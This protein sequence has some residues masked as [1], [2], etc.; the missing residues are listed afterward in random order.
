MPDLRGRHR[1]FRRRAHFRRR[2]QEALLAAPHPQ[3]SPHFGKP[4]KFRTQRH[5]AAL[6]WADMLMSPHEGSMCEHVL[7]GDRLWALASVKGEFFFSRIGFFFKMPIEGGLLKYFG[8][9][10]WGGNFV[11]WT[12]K[13]FFTSKGDE[14]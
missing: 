8:W 7:W 14:N 10:F 2:G 5:F 6:G 1:A 11:L 13:L 4:I 12:L 3:I 9:C